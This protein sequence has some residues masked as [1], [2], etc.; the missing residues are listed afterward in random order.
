MSSTTIIPWDL[1]SLAVN[2]WSL[3]V[4]TAPTRACAR[5]RRSRALARFADPFWVRDRAS[6]RAREASRVATSV[7]AAVATTAAVLTPTSTPTA[8][9]A[10]LRYACGAGGRG[11]LEA[12][13]RV[14]AATRVPA[15]G[16]VQYP[17]PAADQQAPELGLGA[18]RRGQGDP[19]V[20]GDPYPAGLQLQPAGGGEPG[21]VPVA[22]LEPGEP[23][24]ALQEA[25]VRR[26][27]GAD[28][29]PERPDRL[30]AMPRRG[31]ALGG[32]PAADQ[33]EV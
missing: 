21:P 16:D 33:V 2:W 7:P 5:P 4:P 26:V 28:A 1:A 12:H 31:H 23:G 29:V 32:V 8:A 25:G 17:G 13:R 20:P 15:H 14:P 27:R 6:R 24:L 11:P 18:A 19:P 30:A 22:G 3:L 9:P 10:G